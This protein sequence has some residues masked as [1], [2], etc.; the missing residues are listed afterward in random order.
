MIATNAFGMGIDKSNVRYVLHFN[1]PQSMENYYQ[2]AGRAGRDGAPAECILYYSPQDTVINRYLLESKENYREYT[3]EELRTIQSRD[4]ERLRKMEGYCTT[5][6]CLR[7]YILKYFGEQA[8][9]SC[10]NCSNCLE[11]FEE[12]DVSEAAADVIR[13]V[14]AS[15]QR[16]GMNLI[17]GTLLGENTTRIRSCGMDQNPSYGKQDGLGQVRVKEVIRAMMERGYLMQTA[18]RYPVLRLTERSQELLEQTEPFPLRYKKEEEQNVRRKKAARMEELT[19]K[20]QELFE[21]L[22]RL[23]AKLAGGTFDSAPIWWASD[24]TLRDMCIRI[25][26]TAEEMLKVN[27]MG[28]RK[29]EQYGKPVSGENP[30]SD[31]RK[32]RRLCCRRTGRDSS[33]YGEKEEGKERGIPSDRGDSVPAFLCPGD[34]HQRFCVPD[35]RSP[36]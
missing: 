23:R 16:F 13:C 17:A 8:E 5:T 14:Q 24:K 1:M 11:E 6:E 29:L 33:P 22:R 4:M 21:E 26:L 25:P 3:E 19:E 36:G 15:G 18:D 32:N 12:M 34:N 7:G 27:G 10:G 30:G 9:E 2:E 35:Q 20:G 28:A 31:W